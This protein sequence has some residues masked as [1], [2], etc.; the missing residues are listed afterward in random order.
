[1]QPLEA[2]PGDVPGGGD[3]GGGEGGDDGTGDEGDDGTEPTPATFEV[4]DVSPAIDGESGGEIV[5]LT[6]PS[7][8]QVCVNGCGIT[9]L[10][11]GASTTLPLTATEA[12]GGTFRLT[13][14]VPAGLA[15]SGAALADI[16][17]GDVVVGQVPL[18]L[19]ASTPLTELPPIPAE[20][21]RA[22]GL[23]AD[24]GWSLLDHTT[25][26]L[27]NLAGGVQV[28]G[29]S[30]CCSQMDDDDSVLYDF[31]EGAVI[32][33]DFFASDDI[34]IVGIQWS[35][36]SLLDIGPTTFDDDL[37]ILEVSSERF[38]AGPGDAH[39]GSI[40][41]RRAG[42]PDA[43]LAI[44][45]Q[46]G[47]IDAQ[48]LT[49]NEDGSADVQELSI[50]ASADELPTRIL[51]ITP[52]RLSDGSLTIGVLGLTEVDTGKWQ[53]RWF[54]GRKVYPFDTM[55]EASANDI[56]AG[57]AFLGLVHT[58]DVREPIA[59]SDA[60]FYSFAPAQT[61]ES[62]LATVGIHAVGS[63]VTNVR[64]L[65]VQDRSSGDKC[66]TFS[67][68]AT[69]TAVSL[70]A[71]GDGS[72]DLVLQVFGQ[73]SDGNATH[74]D[75]LLPDYATKDATSTSVRLDPLLAAPDYKPAAFGTW[76]LTGGEPNSPTGARSTAQKGGP[77]WLSLDGIRFPHAARS[78]E[79][80]PSS[81]QTV[82]NTWSD[83]ALAAAV[84]DSKDGP[85][86]LTAEGGGV[87]EHH[88][89]RV[90]PAN[91]CSGRGICA[92][93][94]CFCD[95][96]FSGSSSLVLGS[97][98]GSADATALAISSGDPVLLSTA[99]HPT[100]FHASHKQQVGSEITVADATFG[101]A[102]AAVVVEPS[103]GPLTWLEN[104]REP[105]LLEQA[106][107]VQLWRPEVDD[108]V[109]AG[110]WVGDDT[111]ALT[112]DHTITRPRLLGFVGPSRSSGALR[113]PEEATS[114]GTSRPVILGAGHEGSATLFWRDGKGQAWLAVVDIAEAE[115]AAEGEVPLRAGPMAVGGPSA[116]I[117]E[118][119]ELND[120]RPLA[121]GF[122]AGPPATL[123]LAD[124]AAARDLRN[125]DRTAATLPTGPVVMVTVD[126]QNAPVGPTLE[127]GAPCPL[128]NLT[129]PV[130]AIGKDDWVDQVFVERTTEPTCA[131]LAQPLAAGRF[132]AD[133]RE[134]VFRVDG[135]GQG[136]VTGLLDEG[137]MS[138][139]AVD[140]P[141]F[142]A[143]PGAH[144]NILAG[145]IAG[146]GDTDGDG[147]DEVWVTAWGQP[148]P[149]VF[150]PGEGGFTLWGEGNELDTIL[151]LGQTAPRTLDTE[152]REQ[153][154]PGPLTMA[155]DL[156]Y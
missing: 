51:D 5:V 104:G 135:S 63:T 31:N 107:H 138:T 50:A 93:G 68:P 140:N 71:D 100:L 85:R 121:V 88:D 105:L 45:T 70:D 110:L 11:D 47:G 36:G 123:L 2:R 147:I 106:D 139:I 89:Q 37:D 6:E 66:D 142:E 108:E 49:P 55:G 120:D 32:S 54:D 23:P 116:D 82:R 153:P 125:P 76:T 84:A 1:M 26:A 90:V 7:S 34:D 112:A 74:S 38:A 67:N 57:T 40:T 92:H 78:V 115:G 81:W 124:S 141:I 136:S 87:I 122:S 113:L 103:S 144:T 98:S 145:M 61:R 33:D 20:Y 119:L 117:T 114:G 154:R 99:P 41:V 131:D 27:E 14:E 60:L 129:L 28:A 91:T 150:G 15:S 29:M 102:S 59:A 25:R 69:A 127:E 148:V 48:V 152:L 19:R 16:V 130:D 35:T 133:G 143:S 53:G 44:I 96:G 52:V 22:P 56:A 30:V 101:E 10:V 12:E 43:M 149:L 79:V 18:R 95:P 156:R 94:K 146:N 134:G 39:Q 126:L 137:E 24:G 118:I 46:Q 64:S 8:G 65:K 155:G 17:D 111:S 9:F 4:L 86:A 77:G 73:D 97:G 72:N 132:F 13:G 75:H 128:A 58:G 151:G 80:L 3:E 109:I 21:A 62:C 83:S 42:E